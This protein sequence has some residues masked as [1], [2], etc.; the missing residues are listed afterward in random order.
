MA[1]FIDTDGDNIIDYHPNGWTG[2]GDRAFSA[3]LLWSMKYQKPFGICENTEFL[4]DLDCDGHDITEELEVDGDTPIYG[5]EGQPPAVQ[6]V[7]LDGDGDMDLRTTLVDAAECNGGEC[8][9]VDRIDPLTNEAYDNDDY[10]FDYASH[11]CTYWLVDD[12]LDGDGFVAFISPFVTVTDPITENVRPVG[13]V[14]VTSPDGIGGSVV[15]LECDNCPL[16]FNP[17]QYDIDC[18]EVGDLC[19][20]C[21]W[22]PNKDQTNNC[23]GF[24]DGDCQGNVCDN[25]IC[26]ANPDQADADFDTVGDAC[27]NCIATFNTDQVESDNGTC[28]PLFTSDGI[29][30]ACDNCP[31]ACNPAQTD[32][33]F[34]GVGDSCDNCPLDANFDQANADGDDLGDACDRCPNDGEIEDEPDKDE[35]GVG[36]SCDNCIDLANSDQSDVDLDEQGDVCDNCPTYSNVLQT[37]SDPDPTTQIPDG[38]GDACDVCPEIYNPSQDDRD[39]DRVGDLCD[40]C[41]DTPDAGFTDSDD[42]NIT[43]V[44]DLCITTPVFDNTD[45]DGDRI[46]TPCDNCPRHANPGQEDEDDDGL[47]DIC[48]PYSIRGGGTVTDGCSTGSSAPSGWLGLAIGGLLLLRRRSR[49]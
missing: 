47:G 32:G 35:D 6:W 49:G 3:P 28:L 36:D 38:I 5:V 42:D 11:G 33:D 34:D 14:V 44:C 24:P 39:G 4:Q 30:D 43:D 16:D 9:C 46:G 23:F 29:G 17:E 26:A 22:I 27:D 2:D 10:Y 37:D 45:Y 40:G 15:T 19:D 18:D 31:R 7:D 13:Q 12:D 48:D 25:C 1:F 8:T 21:Q 41:P 20:N